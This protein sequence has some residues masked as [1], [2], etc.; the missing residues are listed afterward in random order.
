MAGSR[1]S[2]VVDVLGGKLKKDCSAFSA[3][4]EWSVVAD[5]PSAP[6]GPDRKLS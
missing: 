1:G 5:P 6:E 2:S 4:S 3:A